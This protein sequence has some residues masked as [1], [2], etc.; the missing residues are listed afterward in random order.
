MQNVIS[1]SS[2]KS[3]VLALTICLM[4]LA[5]CATSGYAQTLMSGKDVFTND[6]FSPMDAQNTGNGYILF[7]RMDY[8]SSDKD[9]IYYY[10]NSLSLLKKI[11]YK[12]LI[13]TKKSQFLK[14]IKMN[15]KNYIISYV[16]NDDK[17]SNDI[18]IIPIT[19]SNNSIEMGVEKYL[20]TDVSKAYLESTLKL[21]YSPD[22]TWLSIAFQSYANSKYLGVDIY[23][24]N[25]ELVCEYQAHKLTTHPYAHQNASLEDIVVDNH[26]NTLA[27]VHFAYPS[28]KE[29]PLGYEWFSTSAK[30]KTVT[31]YP[32]VNA[33]NGI[34][35]MKPAIAQDGE[36]II[37]G[38]L[39]K[40][41]SEKKVKV[42]DEQVSNGFAFCEMNIETG[43]LTSFK[44]I[45]YTEDIY[46][47]IETPYYYQN[48][49]VKV[50]GL[51]GV[52]ISHVVPSRDGGFFLVAKG[53]GSFY[54]I[55]KI[56]NSQKLEYMNSLSLTS[57]HTDISPFGS[58]SANDIIVYESDNS[59]KIIANNDPRN[60]E[61]KE[62]GKARIY[63]QFYN[64]KNQN[65]SVTAITISAEGVIQKEI[66]KNIFSTRIHKNTENEILLLSILTDSKNY[67]DF[68]KH[69]F[70]VILK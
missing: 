48:A 28:A 46:K 3:T 2:A 51:N 16:K 56:S 26:G 52:V 47:W 8:Y 62:L 14:F 39:Y 54:F 36:T 63:K 25:S 7:L 23:T 27:T 15:K 20:F 6:A 31:D 19:L 10:N 55:S 43:K 45:P 67:I 37:V 49:N 38:G 70:T 53:L 69:G 35:T 50:S 11:P 61:T 29:D 24:I 21:S 17:K 9:S 4:L 68:N 40:D 60:L 12:F 41:P 30:R 65:Y 13:K 34:T 1:L 33:F 57:F 42:I 18:Y 44:K 5:V 66:N 59:L 64:T 32:T 58:I 22:S